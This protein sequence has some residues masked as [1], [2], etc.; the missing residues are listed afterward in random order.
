MQRKHIQ[1]PIQIIGLIILVIAL[2]LMVRQ[3]F[4]RDVPSTVSPDNP[5]PTQKF[6]LTSSAIQEEATIPKAY[7]CKGANLS[8]PLTIKHTPTNAKELVL[9]M[10]EKNAESGEPKTHWIVWNIPPETTAISEGTIAEEFIEGT[11]DFGKAGYDGPCPV[12][13]S[14]DYEY[15][16]ELYALN[17]TLN[18]DSTTTRDQLVSNINGKVIT[19]TELSARFSSEIN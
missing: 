11:N 15:I 2:S 19:K 8:L 18:L 17:D 6:T 13:N 4:T 1:T 12:D 5:I 14:G 16:L 7:S 3:T 10:R 9:I